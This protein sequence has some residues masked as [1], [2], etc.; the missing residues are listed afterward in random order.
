MNN[1]F[2]M[3]IAKNLILFLILAVFASCKSSESTT[4]PFEV[5]NGYFYKNNQPNPAIPIVI[6]SDS[7]LQEKFG[8]AT[9]MNSR[10][11]QIDFTKQ[12]IIAIVLP[13]TENATDLKINK[14][15]S[16]ENTLLV[17][18]H[19]AEKEKQ[20]FTVQP[21]SMAIVDKSKLKSNIV[22]TAE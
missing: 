6:T 10:P 11:T 15:E 16:S 3:K 12:A 18:Y 9:T 22:A 2:V 17:K 7:Q 13:P 20:S 19:V 21:I 1:T 4:I 14:I 5:A 8:F